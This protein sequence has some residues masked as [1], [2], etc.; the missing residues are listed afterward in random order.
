MSF[1]SFHFIS[2]H[3]IHPFIHSFHFIHSFIHSFHFISFHFMS[4]M[5]FH[6]ISFHPFIHSFIHS[7]IIVL[8]VQPPSLCRWHISRTI[9]SLDLNLE[10]SKLANKEELHQIRK[11]SGSI[12]TSRTTVSKSLALLYLLS[13]IDLF[14]SCKAGGQSL[15]QRMAWLLGPWRNS[16]ISGPGAHMHCIFHFSHRIILKT[17]DDFG[18]DQNLVP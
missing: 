3:F 18:T 7:H 6:F 1:M 14:V 13:T 11:S 15:R 8:F 2:F 5:A 4:F 12:M 16:Q 9:A 10:A 17:L